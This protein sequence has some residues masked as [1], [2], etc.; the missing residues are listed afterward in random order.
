MVDGQGL[1]VVGDWCNL[2]PGHKPSPRRSGAWKSAAARSTRRRS[3][4]PR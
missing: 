1:M 4:R 3:R 2:P